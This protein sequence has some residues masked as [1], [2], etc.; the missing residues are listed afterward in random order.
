MS[1]TKVRAEYSYVLNVIDTKFQKGELRLFLGFRCIDGC[2]AM[3][4][5]TSIIARPLQPYPPM[6]QGY[7]G[8]E[9]DP[10]WRI[11]Q[12]KKMSMDQPIPITCVG[13]GN[14]WVK[15]EMG[16]PQP[17]PPYHPGYSH[18]PMYP[19]HHGHGH[20]QQQY[21]QHLG[22]HQGHM[23]WNNKDNRWVILFNVALLSEVFSSG[24]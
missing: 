24:I 11:P 22:A 20:P 2:S 7:T 16:P 12:Y 15:T 4:A 6:P 8:P 14:A 5:N 13:G 23:V 21:Q 3:S 9:G 19:P 1:D 10:G 18:H 17:P